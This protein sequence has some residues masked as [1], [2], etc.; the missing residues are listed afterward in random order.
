MQRAHSALR[1][2]LAAAWLPAAAAAQT[3]RFVDA[4]AASGI[5]LVTWSGSVEK[6]HILE[7]TG[8]GVLVLDY[9]GDGFEDLYFVAA[10]RLPRRQDGD[11]D[12]GE[13]SAL[14]R[15]QGDGTFLDVS[16]RAGVAARVYGNGGCVGDV[17]GDGLPDL[18]VTAFG[19]NLLYR[20]Q[21]D[22]TFRELGEAAGVA[23]GRWS[24]GATLF[25]ADGDGD[26]DLYVGN[27]VE[28]SWDDVL[29]ARRTRMW[30][31]K[32]A[33]MDGPR[34]LPES[35]NGFY[36]NAGDGTFG[37][38]T[39][40]AGLE[41]GPGPGGAG[42]S[43]AVAAFDYDG[44]G[45]LDLYVAN[46]STANR[47][48]RNRGDGV[49]D[50]VGVAAGVAYNADGR[51][52]GSM[53]VGVGDYD[54]DGR[55]DL[56]V[57]N[58]A[59]DAYTLYRNLGDGQFEDVS[60]AT[61]VALPTFVPLGWAAL[62]L[63]AEGDGDLDLFFANGHIY[64]Q[65]D[66]DPSLEESYRQPDQLLVNEGGLFRDLGLAAGDVATA[67][68][69]SRGAVTVDL[70]ND[71]DLDLVVSHQDGRPSVLRN[72]GFA[73]HWLELATAVDGHAAPAVRWTVTTLRG[74]QIRAPGSGGGYVSQSDRRAH[75]GLGAAA[76]A[77]RVE[78]RWVGGVRRA[79]RG[80]P[81][82]RVVV[83]PSPAG[84]GGGAWR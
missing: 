33:V 30:R 68:Q 32:V 67:A 42:Y 51:A 83:V 64:P 82:D 7:S 72:E 71:G 44:D 37:D 3:P 31:G 69:S 5:D 58:F 50:E 35:A 27:Y 54:D 11:R 80:V 18:Y 13:R 8:N 40:A 15:N 76:R 77:E 53:G 22:G 10:Y 23:D 70:E 66:D 60:F 17:D 59:H 84:S 26:E 79:W 28:A 75:F 62:F 14:Y 24:L 20:N 55:L 73:G 25:D 12:P 1:V 36:R 45:D 2:A 81:A 29:A 9:D 21:G 43:M 39:A 47:L 6:P 49:F 56:A 48:Y 61:R 41:P 65:V 4:T 46:D 74:S 19:P 78:A 52:Q 16:A 63:D 34:G 57:T 38:A